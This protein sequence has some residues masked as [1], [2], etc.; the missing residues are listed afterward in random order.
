MEILNQLKSVYSTLNSVTISG[1][2]NIDKLYGCFYVLTHV[3]QELETQELDKQE[4]DET[5]KR[6]VPVSP[7]E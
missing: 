4:K 3:I 6:G 1:S 2:A 7:T 5:E